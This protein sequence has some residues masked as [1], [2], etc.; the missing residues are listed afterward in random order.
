MQYELRVLRG[1]EGMT[2][3]LLEAADTREA[4]V[5]AKARGYSVI[6]L[7][8]KKQWSPLN[9]VRKTRFP[10]VMF[11]Q[12]LVALLQAGL[13]LIEVLETLAEKEDQPEVKKT[14]EQIIA[15]LYKG[16]KLSYALEQCPRDF[17]PPSG[18]WCFL[19]PCLIWTTTAM[20]MSAQ[21][22]IWLPGP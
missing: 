10:L 22:P 17:P 3:L 21:I 7:S 20:P 1:N 15:L 6:S 11:S 4:E 18:P 12:E 9:L 13:S 5:L 2:S 14:L 8:A 16:H 19:N